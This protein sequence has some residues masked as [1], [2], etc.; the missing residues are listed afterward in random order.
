[1]PVVVGW[2]SALVCGTLSICWRMA[3]AS[4]CSSSMMRQGSDLPRS[5][6]ASVR[7]PAASS[8]LIMPQPPFHT[9]P[10]GDLPR[11]FWDGLERL[12]VLLEEPGMY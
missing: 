3:M 4:W 11:H 1:M 10:A 7:Q 5:R 9:D 8:L 12:H 6:T 2:D